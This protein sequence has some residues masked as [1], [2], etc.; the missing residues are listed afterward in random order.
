MTL[1]SPG[2]WIGDL[3]ANW[4][5]V[6]IALLMLVETVFPPIPSEVI[7]PLAGLHAAQGGAPLW[8]VIA[9]GAIG[10][11]AGNTLW[12][13]L[14]W[15]LGLDRFDR[16]LLRYGRLLTLDRSDVDHGR[17]LFDRYGGGIVGVGR[18]IPTIRSLISVPAGLVRMPI[19]PFLLWSTLGTFTWTTGLAVAG[20]LLGTRFEA[21]DRVIGPVSTAVIL[22]LFL[23]YLWRVVT[24]HRRPRP[25]SRA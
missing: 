2:D 11:M 14:A 13:L 24:W 5:L 23:V 22:V 19:R 20:Y 10:A 16:F 15:R 7:M 9:A 1:S 12:Y 8:A 4:G 17:R 3:I 21:V 6:A 18:V 25:D